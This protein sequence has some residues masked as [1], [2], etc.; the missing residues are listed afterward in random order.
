MDARAHS[1]D[2]KVDLEKSD[3]QTIFSTTPS[4]PRSSWT[5]T[6][7]DLPPD[8]GA[9]AWVQVLM[10]HLVLFNTWGNINSF[11]VFQTHYTQTLGHPHS[12]ISW[13]GSVQIFLSFFV[14]TLSGRATDAGFFSYV[15]LAGSL[16]SLCGIFMTSLATSY[17]QVFLAQGICVGIGNGLVIC[18][19]M[20]VL[21]TYFCRKRSLAIGIAACGGST[22][23]MAFTAIIQSLVPV[24]GFS[25]TIRVLGLLSTV[26]AIIT[27]VFSRTRIPSRKTGPLIEWSAFKEPSYVWFA[28]G[29][30]LSQWGFFIA[31]YFAGSFGQDVIQLNRSDSSSLL[32]IMNGISILG[33]L[34]PCYFGGD[35][36]FGP[37]NTLLPIVLISGVMQYCWI[38]V[39]THAGLI[40]FSIIYGFFSAGIQTLFPAAISGLTEDMS[41]TGVRMGMTYTIISFAVL[42]GPPIAGALIQRD[43]GRYLYAQLFGGTVLI[44]GSLVLAAA[45]IASTGFVLRKKV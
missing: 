11:G 22:G 8:G 23:G 40:V 15:F 27:N 7:T 41:K 18:P 19:T 3:D 44:G 9:A 37:L 34:I 10:S 42:T 4:S 43:G 17:W 25:W 24:I 6:E 39:N 33:R 30:F 31:Y 32:L 29:M 12:H 45:R 36:Y 14:A 13:V 26:I 2:D 21:S 5:K 16:F 28:I 38:A 1:R 35:L 20:S